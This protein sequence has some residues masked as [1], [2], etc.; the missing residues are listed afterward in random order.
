V[1]DQAQDQQNQ[2]STQANVKSAKATEAAEAATAALVSPIFD[3]PAC[4]TRCPTHAFLLVGI[5]CG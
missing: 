4:S 2:H 3:I 1:K 5:R